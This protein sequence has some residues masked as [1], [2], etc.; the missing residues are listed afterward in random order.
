[1]RT[2]RRLRKRAAPRSSPAS[3]NQMQPSQ[4]EVN[5]CWLIVK[6]SA[7][8]VVT[9][10]GLFDVYV[11]Q[12]AASMYLFGTVF[13][14]SG[15][16][17]ASEEEFNSLLRRAWRKKREWPKRL[18]VPD[19]IPSPNPFSIVAKRHRIPVEIVPKAA[20]AIYINDVQAGFREYFGSG[21]TG[22]A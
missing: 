21:E 11:V 10:E 19:S 22:A 12:D 17:N 8:P 20:L 7:A 9:G 6:A 1:M 14:P 5:E 4:F 16:G 2:T 13:T 18:L 3:A 15:S